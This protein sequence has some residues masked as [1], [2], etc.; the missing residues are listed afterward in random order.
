MKLRSGSLLHATLI[1]LVALALGCASDRQPT[2]VP[3]T[4]SNDGASAL[5]PA[6]PPAPAADLQRV[7]ERLAAGER[8]YRAGLDWLAA[9]EE[10]L[11]E[12]ILGEAA[13]VLADAAAECSA[14]SGC[15]LTRVFATYDRLLSTQ[16]IE[17]KR[18][19]SR[20]ATLEA[21][22][23]EDLDR[24]PGTSSFVA[25][26]P[27]I[28]RT[29]SLL[30]GTDL[31]DIITLNGPVQAALDDWLTWMRPMLIEAWYNYQYLR[32]EMAP[33]YEREGLP[34]ALL[35]AMIATESGGKVHATSRAGA[36][37]PL[38]FMR[39]TGQKY[40]LGVVDG[41]DERLDPAAATAAN[42]AYL[43]EQF[44]ALNN[45]L[46]T[47]LAAY[48]GG[49]NRVQSLDRRLRGASFWDS[50]FY[51]ALPRE[52]REYV[53]RVLAAAWLFLHPQDFGLVFPSVE[54]DKTE[55][56]LER[57]ASVGELTIC[58]GQE[59]NPDGWFRTLRNLNPRLE[60]GDRV[61][62]GETIRVPASLVPVYRER[63]LDGEL[64][65]RAEALHGANYPA[66]P[67]MI[68]YVVQQGDTL[69][70]IASRHRC[71]SV[72]ALAEINGIRPPRYVIRAGQML[73]I[74]GCD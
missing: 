36:M 3:A 34:E 50:R 26:M 63:C 39:R 72:R 2:L 18:T 4:S 10:V 41:F 45:D 73:K 23:A 48:N 70:R 46:E 47:A 44:Q 28:E 37:G 57:E 43:N 62:A 27:E 56:R 54:P 68:H 32:D 74:P 21:E 19:V 58:L 55:L 30:R 38:Q 13:H 66:E 25:S 8:D 71:V 11:G 42:V 52:T 61:A 33:V 35:F 7:Y 20:F 69:G 49:E 14:A 17:L 59:G 5:A 9:G 29:V 53:P 31:R 22:L 12:E 16:N 15:D 6:D 65:E 24:E 64:V 51:Y 60:P 40:G 67:E 1:A